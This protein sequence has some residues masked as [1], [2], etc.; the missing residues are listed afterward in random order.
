MNAQ[1][2]S[3]SHYLVEFFAIALFM[4]RLAASS[5]TDLSPSNKF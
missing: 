3:V 4:H 1:L 5:I 2:D